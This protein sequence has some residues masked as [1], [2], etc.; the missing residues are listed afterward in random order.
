MP[1]GAPKMSAARGNI[2]LSLVLGVWWITYCTCY[3]LYGAGIIYLPVTW[4]IA[5]NAGCVGPVVFGLFPFLLA[6][7]AAEY[8]AKLIPRARQLAYV[9]M[10]VFVGF[11]IVGALLLFW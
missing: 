2:M 5:P 11:V 4:F 3:L 8:A 1:F 7:S 6:V 10:L 9:Q